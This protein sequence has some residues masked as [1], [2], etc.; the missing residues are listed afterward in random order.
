MNTGTTV[1]MWVVDMV[2]T[3]AFIIALSPALAFSEITPNPGA[4]DPH[5]R[6]VNYNP[7]QVVRVNTFYGV[8][9]HIQFE[10]GEDVTNGITG[11]PVNWEIKN[12]GNHLSVR[13]I[14]DHAD[15][16]L[17]VTSNKRTYNFLLIVVDNVDVND[18]KGFANPNIFYS[19]FFKYPDVEEQK[20]LEKEREAE[21][22]A[23]KEHDK[24]EIEKRFDQALSHVY[25][26]DYWGN[27]D[28]EIFPTAAH[29]DGNFVWLEFG[30]NGDTP[31]VYEVD[32]E[33]K[34]SIVN[35]HMEGNNVVIERMARKYVL[36][37]GNLVAG[38]VNNSFAKGRDNKSGTVATDVSIIVKE[39]EDAK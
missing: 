28:N 10:D 21:E 3:L 31:N 30:N 16:N 2:K 39:T 17:T 33:G 4:F 34:E 24:Q 32:K 12:F 27:G 29:D 6:V 23:K 19:L 18:P 1:K 9:T 36:R 37:R 25:N 7:M 13:P 15:T 20:R 35:S 5:V 11:A 8:A 14:K 22:L 26:E 38:I